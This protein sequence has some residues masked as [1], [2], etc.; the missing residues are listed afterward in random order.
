M[1]TIVQADIYRDVYED[2]DG[3][4]F[5]LNHSCLSSMSFGSEDMAWTTESELEAEGML[6]RFPHGSSTAI[7]IE[8]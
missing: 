8:I 7:I 2:E 4:I 6:A 1:Y 3:T 5:Y